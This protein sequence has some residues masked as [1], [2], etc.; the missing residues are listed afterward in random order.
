MEVKRSAVMKKNEEFVSPGQFTGEAWNRPLR[1]RAPSSRTVNCDESTKI[2]V[3][4]YERLRIK[5]PT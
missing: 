3:D 5:S 1:R 2:F 4:H